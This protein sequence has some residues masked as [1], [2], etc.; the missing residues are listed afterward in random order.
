MVNDSCL[1]RTKK[2]RVQISDGRL[3]LHLA[4]DENGAMTV[5]EVAEPN[6]LPA[7]YTQKM[8]LPLAFIPSPADVLLIGLGGG[9]QAK[10]IHRYLPELRTIGLEIDAEVV[11]LARA[12]FN[13]PA[14][15]ERL[16]VVIQDAAEFV[17]NHSDEQCDLI[18]SDAFG[19]GYRPVDALHTVDFYRECH[20]ILRTGGVMTVNVY[21]PTAEWAA[22]FMSTVSSVFTC[23]KFIAISPIQGVMVLWKDRPDLNW[24]AVRERAARLDSKTGLGFSAFVN[25]LKNE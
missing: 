16:R 3:F 5:M 22:R 25:E 23:R 10:F 14:D 15:D 9:Q 24:D 13:L 2:Y 17:R 11:E 6:E 21:E 1:A 8:L 18:L 19:E 20:R 4:N 12:H 7:L